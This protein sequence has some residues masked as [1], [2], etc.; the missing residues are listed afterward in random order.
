MNLFSLLFNHPENKIGAVIDIESD[1]E[2]SFE[3][4]NTC[5]VSYHFCLDRIVD[6]IETNSSVFSLELS[7]T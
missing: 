2:T 1:V 5:P 6:T 7:F 4:R 3:S